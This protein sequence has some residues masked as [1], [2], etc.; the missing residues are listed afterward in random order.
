MRSGATALLGELL[1][2][3]PPARVARYHQGDGRRVLLLRLGRVGQL[4]VLPL[5][6]SRYRRPGLEPRT[7]QGPEG[8]QVPP[9]LPVGL[10][11]RRDV[12]DALLPLVRTPP[13]VALPGVPEHLPALQQGRERLDGRLP[14]VRRRR[15][16]ARLDPPSAAPGAAAPGGRP[17][18]GL[19]LPGAAAAG[20][21]RRDAPDAQNHR[22]RAPLCDRQ[23]AA[24]RRDLLEH[25]ERADSA[26]AGA[27]VPLSQLVVHAERSVPAGLRGGAQG[28]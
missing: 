7:A 20:R 13:E 12:P 5:V 3:R 6:W 10:R 17:P 4:L 26:R 28:V 8:L 27:L 19:E 14:V 1:E 18:E 22:D 21:F 16:R 9:A 23:A 11:R 2:L 24:T 25:A 15:H